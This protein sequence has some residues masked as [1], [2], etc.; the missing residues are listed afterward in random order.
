VVDGLCCF[1]NWVT[2]GC[3]FVS[4]EDLDFLRQLNDKWEGY[5]ANHNSLNTSGIARCLGRN[6]KTVWHAINYG[7]KD[8]FTDEILK[9]SYDKLNNSSDPYKNR[10]AEEVKK[11]YKN[12]LEIQQTN[13]DRKINAL[14]YMLVADSVMMILSVQSTIDTY[15]PLLLSKSSSI[16]NLKV[17]VHCKTTMN[18]IAAIEEWIYGNT[19]VYS[20]PIEISLYEREDEPGEEIFAGFV[21]GELV[22]YVN[23]QGYT[24]FSPSEK[25]ELMLVEKQLSKEQP[26][27]ALPRSREAM[28]IERLRR[29]LKD[30]VDFDPVNSDLKLS[31]ELLEE[32]LDFLADKAAAYEAV[33][34][35]IK[36]GTPLNRLRDALVSELED[37]YKDEEKYKVANLVEATISYI[38]TKNL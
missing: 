11:Y 37:R 3:V 18:T 38:L 1:T 17:V 32:V 4:K 36:E 19:E 16:K 23:Q 20:Q 9:E 28:F 35:A 30:D 14:S 5:D 34:P 27:W 12:R 33:D 25:Q 6:E 13:L 26:T 31:S 21:D 10:L 7:K 8:F 15:L 2:F 24:E 22:V 29:E